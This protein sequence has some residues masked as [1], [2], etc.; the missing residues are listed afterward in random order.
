MRRDAAPL[1]IGGDARGELG[2]IGAATEKTPRPSNPSSG[3]S[4]QITTARSVVAGGCSPSRQYPSVALFQ[5]IHPLIESNDLE[6][7]RRVADAPSGVAQQSDS[8]ARPEPLVEA[9][10]QQRRDIVGSFAHGANGHARAGAK[11]AREEPDT[12][13]AG[14]GLRRVTRRQEDDSRTR[15]TERPFKGL[16]GEE[17]IGKEQAAVVGGRPREGAMAREMKHV[18]A[19][20]VFE[21]RLHGHRAGAVGDD[22]LLRAIEKLE[23]GTHFVDVRT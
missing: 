2:I 6:E 11:K 14:G 17:A 22:D 18:R 8:A 21:H 3:M 9:S 16:D 15:R 23:G 12:L 7:S 13:D 20:E 4:S 5:R 10:G 1:K 19:P